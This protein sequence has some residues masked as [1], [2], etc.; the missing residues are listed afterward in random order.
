MKNFIKSSLLIGTLG[1]LLAAGITSATAYDWHF[2]IENDTNNGNIA[3]DL[4]IPGDTGDR[5]ITLNGFS[6]FPEFT[7]IG[8]GLVHDAYGLSVSGVPISAV[9]NLQS[10]IDS[11]NSNVTALTSSLTT[12]NSNV[13]T[14]NATLASST[15]KRIRVQTAS[16]GSYTWT[17]PTAFGTS[18][19][20]VITAVAEDGTAGIT[21]VQ[22]TSLSNTSVSIQVSRLTSVLGILTLNTTPQ[23]YVHLEA[24]NP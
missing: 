7:G 3:Y 15:V 22:I 2:L 1:I 17:F 19:M 18:T 14:L 21:N 16:N 24:M 6:K 5:I 23:V 8:T 20:P 10:T 9:T 12:T 4:P 13:S 11:T